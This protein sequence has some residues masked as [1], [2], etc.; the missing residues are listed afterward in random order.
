MKPILKELI[1]LTGILLLSIL[2]YGIVVGN[3]A[4]DINMHDTY[5]LGNG[6][7]SQPSSTTNILSVFIGISLLI[8]L[9]RV[10][11]YRFK[12]TPANLVLMIC[13]GLALFYFSTNIILY[14]TATNTGSIWFLNYS[15]ALILTYYFIKILLITVLGF[16]GFMTGRNFRNQSIEA[17]IVK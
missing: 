15:K 4:I 17:T 9:A 16:T 11:Y 10:S 12:K 3:T 2:I 6:Q 13:N 5:I 8:Y 14:L 1:W 7:I